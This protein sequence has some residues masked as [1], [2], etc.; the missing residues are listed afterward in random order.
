MV[1][2]CPC[3]Q[4]GDTMLVVSFSVGLNHFKVP[5]SNTKNKSAS[6]ILTIGI[7]HLDVRLAGCIK[8]F[9]L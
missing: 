7:I 1:T 6:Y 3:P 9:P 2:E 8:A 4:G 5:L